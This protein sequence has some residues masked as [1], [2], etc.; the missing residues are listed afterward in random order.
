MQLAALKKAGCKTPVF[1]D[2]VTGAHVNRPA[3]TR[4]PKI[5]R[6]GDTLIVWKLDRLGRSLRDLILVGWLARG[7]VEESNGFRV[8]MSPPVTPQ[9]LLEG[10]VYALEQCGLLLRDANILFRSGSYAS[11]VVLAAFAQEELG[12]FIILLNF[13]KQTL[14]GKTFTIK[15]IQDH[16]DDH[17]AKQHA[18]MLSTTMTADRD[19]GLG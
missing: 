5:L 1:K 2:E 7:I 4:C 9:Y 15:E 8:G 18:G 13:R 12:R 6:P 17:V 11:A 14:A 10:A 3:L 19:S 16:C